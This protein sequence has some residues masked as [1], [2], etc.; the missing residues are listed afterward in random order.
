MGVENLSEGNGNNDASLIKIKMFCE[1]VR[2]FIFQR[3]CGCNKKKI[4]Y[5]TQ[6]CRTGTQ[7]HVRSAL[8]SCTTLL[9]GLIVKYLAFLFPKT[10]RIIPL[11]KFVYFGD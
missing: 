1:K 9:S 4:K 11:F 7:W 3:F 8:L 10:F 2:I 6:S 5:V